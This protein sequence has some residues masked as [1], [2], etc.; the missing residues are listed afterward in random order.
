MG[1]TI[2]KSRV[3]MESKKGRVTSK[4]QVTIPKQFYKA[5][6]LDVSSE[7]EFILGD[8]ELIIRPIRNDSGYFS[9][10]ILNELVDK[11]Y[12]GEELKKEFARLTHS[13]KPAIKDMLD[14]VKQRARK[15]MDNYVDE[16]DEI[17]GS[18]D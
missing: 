8:D 11:G 17:F 16:T 10:Q 1:M 4:Q 18:G 5:L 6:N 13:V 12:T 7:I 15:N 2:Q 3:N 9:Q 14:D